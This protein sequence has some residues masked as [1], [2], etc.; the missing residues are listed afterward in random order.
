MNLSK[1]SI[2][3]Q[4]TILVVPTKLSNLVNIKVPKKSLV[5]IINKVD[6]SY[7]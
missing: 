5:V 7:S 4:S 1:C 6:S 3:N 2:S